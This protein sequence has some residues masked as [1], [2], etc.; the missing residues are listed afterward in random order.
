[1][2]K[3]ILF[4]ILLLFPSI[5]NATTYYVRTNGGTATQCT[6]TTDAAYPGSG[7]NQ[8]CAF[9]HPNWAISP[10]GS[11]PTKMV[12]GDILIIDGQDYSSPGNQAQYKFGMDAP[13]TSDTSLCYDNWAWTC[14]QRPIPKGTAGAHTK[15]LGKGYDTGCSQAPILYGQ[16]RVSMV[17]NMQDSDYVDIQCL[18]LTDHSSCVYNGGPLTGC[19]RTTLPFG[20]FSDYGIVASDANDVYMKDVFI[21][22][23]SIGGIHAGR[24]TDWTLD[25]VDIV[26]NGFVG[27]DGDIGAFNSSNSGTMTFKNLEITWNGCQESYP[28]SSGYTYGNCY[29]QDQGGYGDGLGTHQTGGNWVFEN[30]DASHNTSDGIDLLYHNGSGTITVKR[31]RFEGNAGNQLKAATSL[32]VD[33]S[34]FIS[35]CNYFTDSGKRLA[36]ANANLGYSFND[37]R[38]GGNAIALSS[39]ANSQVTIY[40][41]T[42]VGEGDVLISYGGASCNGSETITLANDILHGM[43]QWNT[44]SDKAAWTYN[45]GNDGNGGGPCGTGVTRLDPTITYSIIYNVKDSVCP[46]GS[47]NQCTDPKFIDSMLVGFNS[48]NYNVNLQITSPAIG[49]NAADETVSSLEPGFDF[50]NYARGAQWDTGALEYGSVASCTANGN[51]CSSNGNCCSGYCCTSVCS[52]T[53]CG[54]SVC[55]NGVAEAGEDCDGSDLNSETCI[56]QGYDTG[57]L[58]CSGSCT[59][60]TSGCS[61]NSSPGNGTTYSNIG[62]ITNVLLK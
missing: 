29:S 30:V 38:S 15:I 27:W 45:E 7:T 20:Q 50:N 46:S 11:N 10:I 16:K 52:A 1:M 12:G 53:S 18:E 37:C 51:A 41:S 61:F 17:L 49:T 48:D 62:T 22:G 8:A 4:L 9:N 54:G 14:Y 35:N 57:T 39:P 24:L 2:K 5:G 44:P 28:K 40:N 36:A 58:A 42:I 55:G 59:F 43:E 31:S 3:L 34:K 21:H 26:G 60:N 32:N 19:D 47:N 56:T 23:F 6:G 33:N 25:N 13:N